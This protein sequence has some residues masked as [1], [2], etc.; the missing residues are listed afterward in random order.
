MTL[1]DSDHLTVLRYRT[2]QRAAKLRARLEA[3][4]IPL[5]TTVVNVE[6]AMKGWI[7]GIAKER[8]PRRQTFAY[9]ELGELFEFFAGYQI[10]PFDEAAADEFTR[11]RASKVRIGTSD[12]KIAAVARV[13]DARVLTANRRDFERVPGLRFE[14]WLD[15]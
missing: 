4:G 15:G 14:N 3:A 12:L 13:R 1:L 8:E 5:T 7:A 9:R 10:A 2:S 11:L 6:E